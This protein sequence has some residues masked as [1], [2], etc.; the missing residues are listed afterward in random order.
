M[1]DKIELLELVDKLL[2]NM[3][4]DYNENGILSARLEEI[5]EIRNY[6]LGD[7]LWII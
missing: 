3:E 5:E 1:F 7:D 6:I 2:E 4:L